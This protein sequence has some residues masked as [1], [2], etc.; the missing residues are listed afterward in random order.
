MAAPLGDLEAF[1]IL[2]VFEPLEVF[3]ILEGLEA[4]QILGVLAD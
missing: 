2:E 4:L 3:G 1:G